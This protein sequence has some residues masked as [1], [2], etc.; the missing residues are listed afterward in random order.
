[1]DKWQQMLCN[2]TKSNNTEK[3]MENV[4]QKLARLLESNV[5]LEETTHICKYTD[6]ELKIRQAILSKYSH[7]SI[8]FLIYIL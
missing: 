6:D 8:I 2:V 1:M 7:A 3:I 4:D 5:Q